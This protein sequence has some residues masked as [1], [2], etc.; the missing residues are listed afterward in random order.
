M[1]V[2]A[3]LTFLKYFY[4]ILIFYSYTVSALYFSVFSFEEMEVTI[5]DEDKTLKNRL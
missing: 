2:G 1:S 5:D 3:A 4:Y